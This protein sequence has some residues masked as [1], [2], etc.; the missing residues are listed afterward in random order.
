MSRT[1]LS[2]HRGEAAGSRPVIVLVTANIGN[3]RLP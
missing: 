2:D 1:G 3:I